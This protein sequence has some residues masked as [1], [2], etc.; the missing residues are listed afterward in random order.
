MYETNIFPIENLDELTGTYSL[1]E[2]IGL[3]D[4]DEDFDS[5]IQ[6]IIKSL[7]YSLKH[8]ITVIFREKK[9]FLVVRDEKH[10][11]LK[12]PNEYRVR[13]ND[14]VY[15][16]QMHQS[17]NLDFKNYDAS[18]RHIILRFLQFDIQTELNKI[19][20][21]WQPGSGD[22][23]FS[24]SS[25]DGNNEVAIYNGFIVRIVELPH[26]GFGLCVDITKK[27]I[28]KIPLNFLLTRQQ[29]KNLAITKSHLVYHYGSKRYEIKAEEYSDLNVTQYKFTREKD[30]KVLTLLEDIREKFGTSMPP[31]VAKLPDNGSVLIYRTNDNKERRV[32]AGLCYKVYDTEDEQVKKLHKKSIVIPFYRRKQIRIVY[33]NFLSKLMFGDLKLKVSPIPLKIEK[34]K[35]LTPDLVFG[36]NVILSVQNKNKDVYVPIQQLGRKRKELLLDSRAGFYTK[37]SFETQYFILPDSIYNMFGNEKYF[38][39]DL[40]G[41]VDRMHPTESGW[42]P[43]IIT[44]D[45]R[46]KKH[47]VDIGFEI[48]E[49]VEARINKNSHGYAVI[50]LPS[51]IERNKRQHDELAALVVSECLN[52]Y[53][54]TASVMHSDTLEQCYYHKS[55][56]GETKYF[57]KDELRGKYSGYVKGVAINQV[58]L[59]N[60]RWP[61]VLST[62]L[63]ADL[64]IGIDVKRHIAGFTFI[65][66]YSRNI[67]TKFDKSDKKEK[68]SSSQVIKMLTRFIALQ[69]EYVNYSLKKIVIHRDGRL[70]NTEKVGILEAIKILVDKNILPNDVSINIIEIPKQSIIPFRI[71]ETL[72]EFDVF[73]ENTDNGNVLNPEIGTW[74]KI[75]NKEAFICTTGREFTHD[76]T[77]N[78]LYVKYESGQ[79]KI[80]ELLEDI[81]YLSCLAYSKPDDCSR[82]PLTIKITDSRIN[83]LGSDYDFE[84]L[85]ILKSINEK[86]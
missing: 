26:G 58:L 81:Y 38:L 72:K 66:K 60:E 19:T 85:E 80:E 2:I 17:F 24:K 25:F 41:M 22:A 11:V 14:I 32:P 61:Y 34:K 40:I 16:K 65:D 73:T 43:E 13:Q 42:R 76:G 70:F 69:S 54:I 86:Y 84:R 68:L 21:I 5:N 30:G 71:Y 51:G 78:P 7:S 9:P 29:F 48:I 53:G 1:F 20:N 55:F 10:I 27:Y 33:N 44:Y 36:N 63:H 47:T 57:I 8:P 46:N 28:S 31:E 3:N 37:A 64:T 50:M 79:M 52:E 59:N 39:N 45:D 82:F 15:F 23:F 67:L 56:N 75:N 74:I 18:T 35:F 83:I 62:P 6:Y 12:V 49:K 77:S 4:L